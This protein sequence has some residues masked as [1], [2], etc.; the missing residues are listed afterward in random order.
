[1]VL[2][3]ARRAR[4]ARRKP[5]RSRDGDAAAARV[6]AAAGRAG[7][8]PGSP[9]PPGRRCGAPGR[10]GG[11]GLG[12]AAQQRAELPRR[13]AARPS[14]G[15][16]GPL[17]AA[18]HRE[19]AVPAG[20]PCPG[21]G[22]RWGEALAGGSCRRPG[23]GAGVWCP[24]GQGSPGPAL[25]PRGLRCPVVPL[26]PSALPASAG[27]WGP[28][29]AWG[30]R[31]GPWGSGRAGMPAHRAPLPPPHLP[32]CLP[33]CGDRPFFIYIFF[34]SSPS[35]LLLPPYVVPNYTPRLTQ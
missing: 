16:A 29:R 23:G 26:P 12:P 10:A 5:E 33:A 25:P 14:R 18:R 22:N 13:S 11:M 3:A 35:V 32:L 6:S 9:S 2:A 8:L 34:S 24:A 31:A 28:G 15:V 17:R 30:R 27:R 7:R 21:G 4:V 20:S 1:M 19:G